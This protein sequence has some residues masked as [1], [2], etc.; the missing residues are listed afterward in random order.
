MFFTLF[1][2]IIM[3]YMSEEDLL[4]TKYATKCIK[5]DDA[6]ILKQAKEKQ[7]KQNEKRLKKGKAAE[8]FHSRSKDGAKVTILPSVV[9]NLKIN[10]SPTRKVFTFKGC[11]TSSRDRACI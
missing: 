9:H 2:G 11:H 1:F 6:F 10:K 3:H 8:P 7:D 4:S 5:E